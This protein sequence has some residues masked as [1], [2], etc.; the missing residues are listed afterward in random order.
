MSA[1]LGFGH[2]L[3]KRL[4]NQGFTVFATCLYKDSDGAKALRSDC[5]NRT[6]VLEL[7]ASSD[8]SV[9][10]ALKEVTRIVA[11]KDC[12]KSLGEHD[13]SVSI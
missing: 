2:E 10:D 4:D 6:N 13:T 7:D 12:G 11:R 3:A 5:S 9:A 1:I 8:Q